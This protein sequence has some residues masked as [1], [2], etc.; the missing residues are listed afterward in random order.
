ME[1]QMVRNVDIDADEEMIE[2]VPNG[3]NVANSNVS[4]NK[5][6]IKRNQ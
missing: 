2:V 1:R 6:L 4:K 5:V 3:R